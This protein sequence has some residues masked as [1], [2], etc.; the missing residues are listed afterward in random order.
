VLQYVT[1]RSSVLQQV[2]ACKRAAARCRALQ[3]V[4]VHCSVWQWAIRG[5][6]CLIHMCDMPQSVGCTWGSGTIPHTWGSGTIPHTWG[7]LHTERRPICDAVRCST[8]QCVTARCSALQCAAETYMQCS[9]LQCGVVCCSAQQCVA[10][11]ERKK[12]QHTEFG[13]PSLSPAH[14]SA[15]Q[16]VAV[17]CC[18]LQRR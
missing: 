12:K 3:R 18:V 2:A 15:L 9:V 5:V 1:V 6:H 13:S 17:R 11:E 7:S 10:A 14:C 4:A 8:V 16:C